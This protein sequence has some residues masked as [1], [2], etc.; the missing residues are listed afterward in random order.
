MVV[1][2]NKMIE[3]SRDMLIHSSQN[4]D[5]YSGSFVVNVLA[6]F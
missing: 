6:N 2:T 4:K 1:V 5:G 3:S